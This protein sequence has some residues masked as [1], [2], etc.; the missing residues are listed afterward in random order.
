[1]LYWDSAA[2]A[3]VDAAIADAREGRPRVLV[4][5]GG[6]GSGRS[7]FLREVLTRVEAAG[8]FVVRT[9]NGDVTGERQLQGLAGLGVEVVA[10]RV[11]EA[12]NSLEADQALRDAVDADTERAPLVIAID[13]LQWLDPESVSALAHLMAGAVA[14]RL[15]LV[16]TTGHFEPFQ[17]P[18]WQHLVAVSPLVVPIE[19][20]PLPWETAVRVA[21]DVRP[22]LDTQ[23]ARL[24]WEHTQ[25]NP[26]FYAAT[27]RR[28]TLA[29]L[30]RM[31]QFPAPD[32]YA[33]AIEVRLAGLGPDA[34]ALARAVAVIGAGWMPLADAAYVAEL[35]DPT[36]ARDILDREFV[37]EGRAAKY[38]VEVRFVHAL[39]QASVA[40]FIPV[41]DAAR[42]N[43]RAV[44]VAA[45]EPAELRHRYA[46]ATTHDEQLVGQLVEAA[47]RQGSERA[48]RLAAT[49]FDW[50]ARVSGDGA[51]R[52]RLRM[53][54]FYQWILAG[55]VELVRDRLPDI[56][57]ARDRAGAAL[58]QGMLLAHDN[59]W[60]GAIRVLAPAAASAG[61]TLTAYR[62]EV[63]L[64][65]STM[66]AGGA[67][68][69][70]LGHISRAESMPAR[71]DA[72][73]GLVTFA[74]ALMMGR[75]DLGE[76]VQAE[77]LR[78][79]ARPAAVPMD[80][81]YW[82]AWQ[83]LGLGFD[84][85]LEE[86]IEPLRE[87]DA[88][89]A[90][91]FVDVGDGLTRAFL[92][93]CYQLLGAADVAT[94]YFRAADALRRARPHPLTTAIIA[95]GHTHRGEWDQAAELFEAV[96]GVL[97]DTPWP[98]AVIALLAAEAAYLHAHGDASER[99]ALL[100]R[101]RRSYGEIVDAAPLA[102]PLATP[103]MATAH[104]WAG[105]HAIALTIADGLQAR[106][107]L[108]W[109]GS[110][111]DW[112]RAL[113]TEARGD[114]TGALTLL[115]RAAASASDDIPILP[116]HVAADL[117]R[118]AAA[119]GDAGLA[120][121]S[122]ARADAI[123]RR[124]GAAGYVDPAAPADA[125]NLA[126]AVVS[127]PVSEVPDDLEALSERERE[128][129]AL[130]VRGM[131]YAQIARELY[132]TRSTVGFHLSRI[133]AKTGTTSRHELCELLAQ[134]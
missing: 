34:V 134:V 123:Y 3:C 10:A 4:V 69:D 70:I 65:W 42:L 127:A 83:G 91:G 14:E 131:S 59:D 44:A 79:P 47:E 113:V 130:V 18:D 133:Y 22:E 55:R 77:L 9:G 87:V 49:Y 132:I 94:P 33:R 95:G 120:A 116:A 60:L 30:E 35:D 97:R 74:A 126:V 122:R 12:P 7:S 41:A 80:D 85:R 115:Q 111:A 106:G 25:G 104:L 76:R 108:S 40:Q 17:H 53:E 31:E 19:L 38:G 46:A 51:E 6:P 89:M 72:L 102:G 88:R 107:D 16:V 121:S 66:C 96:H 63:L 67:T 129:V 54:S 57:Q 20:E 36:A 56:R 86:A 71:D 64:A 23:V 11:G 13:D 52:S 124:V 90:T 84:G 21:K 73:A 5:H 103:W 78:L 28:A 50:A 75:S 99:A 101:Y 29:D 119:A 117:A 39:V 37:L 118:V 92:G 112:I 93:W 32:D 26:L 81:T 61:A 48:H 43:S 125:P 24:L 128:V 15:L 2:L 82:L 114:V 1:M 45:D 105:E 98:E 58:V 27:L 110:T 100:A 109:T 68:A 8:R 62:I